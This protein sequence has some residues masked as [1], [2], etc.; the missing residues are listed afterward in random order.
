MYL[1]SD[2]SIDTILSLIDNTGTLKTSE[3]ER[4]IRLDY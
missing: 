1:R 2:Y 4:I 3:M